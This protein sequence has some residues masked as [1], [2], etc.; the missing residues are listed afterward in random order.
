[1]IEKVARSIRHYPGNVA[2]DIK[3]TLERMS[4]TTSVKFAEIAF[5]GSFICNND[6]RAFSVLSWASRLSP[7]VDR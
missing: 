6:I 3:G 7:R 2:N 5:G 4:E 1:V